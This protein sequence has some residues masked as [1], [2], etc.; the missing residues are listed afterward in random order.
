M[1]RHFF[2]AGALSAEAAK[3]NPVTW[4]TGEPMGGTRA[5]STGRPLFDVLQV[6]ASVTGLAGPEPVKIV[7]IERL[8]D[9]SANVTYR[10]VSGLVRQSAIVS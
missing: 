9:D 10:T 1:T 5:E 6:G 4:S 3:V 7:A 2:C 8:T